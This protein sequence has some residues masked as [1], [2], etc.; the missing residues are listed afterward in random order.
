MLR[1]ITEIKMPGVRRA[2]ALLILPLVAIGA[3]AWT[4]SYATQNLAPTAVL[5][6]NTNRPGNAFEP[7][8]VGLATETKEFGSG[9]LS[10]TDIRLVRL[11]RLLGPSVLRIGGDSVDLSWWTSSSEPAPSWAA[12]VV[13][14]ADLFVLHL[15]LAATGWQVLLGVDLGHF[16]PTRVA[17]EARY[18]KLILGNSLLGIE[19]GNEPNAFAGGKDGLRPPSYDADEYLREAKTYIYAIQK[20]APGVATYGPGL[21]QKTAWLAQ[22]E[23]S[24]S[25][26]TGITQHFYA[27]STCLGSPPVVPPTIRGLLSPAERQLENGVLALLVHAGSVA[28]RPTRIGE[29]NTASCLGSQAS[30]LFASALWALDWSLRAVSSG[31]QGMNFPGGLGLC[32]PRGENPICASNA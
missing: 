14:P 11:M 17:D 24:A 19:I 31:V 4:R 28:G 26:F 18:A 7:G 16:E 25:V 13:T 2:V 29:T 5:H 1:R 23:S 21:T 8:A 9:R 22:V 20:S 3:W 30:P 10:A 27:S 15:L 12:N 6:V 32:V